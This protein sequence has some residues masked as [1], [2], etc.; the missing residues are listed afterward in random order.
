MSVIEFL[1][2]GAEVEV[3]TSGMTIRHT[4]VVKE[5]TGDPEFKLKQAIEHPTIPKIGQPN[6]ANPAIFV[7]N[8]VAREQSGT[9]FVTVTWNPPSSSNSQANDTGSATVAG[10]EMDCGTAT[11]DVTTDIHGKRMELGYS[12]FLHSADDADFEEQTDPDTGETRLVKTDESSRSVRVTRHF[13]PKVAVEKPQVT[14][15]LSRNENYFP[16]QKALTFVGRIN[17]TPWCQQKAKTWLC[18]GIRVRQEG[19]IFKCDYQFAFNEKTWQVVVVLSEKG[20]IPIGAEFGNGIAHF[21]VYPAAD[22]N[23]LGLYIPS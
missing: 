17:S 1:R 10:L 7:S 5:L 12:G 15:S 9:A 2:E 4:Y 21:D 20:I 3:D 11:E 13:I 19:Q 22:F 8:I 18:R 6:K 23:T 16:L 14:M